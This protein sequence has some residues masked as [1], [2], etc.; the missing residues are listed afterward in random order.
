MQQVFLQW[1]SPPVPSSRSWVEPWQSAIFPA[2]PWS[3]QTS[4]SLPLFY[5][6]TVEPGEY[7]LS[8][9]LQSRS[10]AGMKMDPRLRLAGMT[11]REGSPL[12]LHGFTRAQILR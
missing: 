9:F 5:W 8:G 10:G 1:H 11:S 2:L 3:L 4:S 7:F 12:T 6:R